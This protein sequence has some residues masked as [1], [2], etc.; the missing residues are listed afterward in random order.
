[1]RAYYRT[2][3]YVQD[4]RKKAYEITNP[5]LVSRSSKS[6][7]FDQYQALVA[8]NVVP[9]TPASAQK[10]F[11]SEGGP[12][13]WKGVWNRSVAALQDAKKGEEAPPDEEGF[14]A[15]TLNGVLRSE[16]AK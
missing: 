13:Y 3:Q 11:F 9:K 4:E 14:V 8:Y 2:A 10:L 15:P 5:Y 16:S 6:M 7:T 1:M 12:A